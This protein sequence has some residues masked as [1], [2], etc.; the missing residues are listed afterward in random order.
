MTNTTE[1]AFINF[2]IA[3]HELQPGAKIKAWTALGNSVHGGSFYG[4]LEGTI[5]KRDLRNGRH[6]YYEIDGKRW[7]PSR[8]VT[9]ARE[10]DLRS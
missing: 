3:K 5:T 1:M 8:D 9:E 6:L 7:I 2:E 10:D 4:W